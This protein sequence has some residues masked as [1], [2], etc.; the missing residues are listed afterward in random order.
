MGLGLASANK[1]T[2]VDGYYFPDKEKASIGFKT[3]DEKYSLYVGFRMQ[4]RFT[5]RD[6]DEDLG[7]RD[8]T[9]IDVRRVRLCFGGNIY[10]KDVKLLCGTRWRQF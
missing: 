4:T 2:P 8:K 5:Y 6:N 1:Y 3:S 7:E 9:D 10:S